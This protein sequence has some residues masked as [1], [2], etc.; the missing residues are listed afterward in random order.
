MSGLLN[1]KFVCIVIQIKPSGTVTI[2][3][4]SFGYR[5]NNNDIQLI[6]ICS[7][8]VQVPLWAHMTALYARHIPAILLTKPIY[9]SIQT[10]DYEETPLC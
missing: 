6:S 1:G 10:Y 8:G 5:T 3:C 4:D 9:V 7:D 2:G